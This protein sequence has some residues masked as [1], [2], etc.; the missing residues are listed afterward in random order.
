[1]MKVEKENDGEEE[2]MEMEVEEEEG[3]CG[4]DPNIPHL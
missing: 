1:M 4:P 3:V 2:L